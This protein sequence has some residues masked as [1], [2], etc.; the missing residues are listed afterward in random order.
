MHTVSLQTQETLRQL[1]A[2]T[3]LPYY[4]EIIQEKTYLLGFVREKAKHRTFFPCKYGN[5]IFDSDTSDDSFI[6]PESI[7][8]TSTRS[9]KKNMPLHVML[10]LLPSEPKQLKIFDTLL[11]QENENAKVAVWYPQDENIVYQYAIASEENKTLWLEML[12]QHVPQEKRLDMLSER[13]YPLT[14]RFHL[15]QHQKSA[16]SEE[17]RVGKEC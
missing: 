12:L 7:K 13:L 14:E 16:R 4:E 11:E 6:H 8:Q 5:I 17:R 10:L 1:G 9:T 2:D 15:K 3:N